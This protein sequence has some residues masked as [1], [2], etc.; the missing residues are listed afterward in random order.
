MQHWSYDYRARKFLGCFSLRFGTQ[1]ILFY[2]LIQNIY[3]LS[4][5]A[6]NIIFSLPSYGYGTSTATQLFSAGWNL[7]GLPFILLGIWAVQ[8]RNGA[9][10]RLFLYY[11][12]A[13]FLVDAFFLADVFFV[14]DACAHLDDHIGATSAG[15]GH[16]H[17]DPLWGVPLSQHQSAVSKQDRA[18]AC[19]VARG[20]ST[21]VC[22]LLL[23]LMAYLVYIV[24][25][26]ITELLHGGS[27]GTIS[28]LMTWQE[29]EERE[30]GKLKEGMI[31]KKGSLFPPGSYDQMP[32]ASL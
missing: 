17:G 11:L 14:K 6:R 20:T 10:L 32:Y 3:S 19:G 8:T 23:V 2:T 21:L 24:W 26:Y 30:W 25:S 27:A 12:Q 18:F 16:L 1:L 22:C 15:K 9:V 5:A 29:Q 7:F 28:R 31:I 4:S 13:S